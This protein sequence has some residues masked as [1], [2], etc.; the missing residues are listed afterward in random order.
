VNVFAPRK[1]LEILANPPEIPAYRQMVWGQPKPTRANPLQR[2][3]EFNQVTV[4]TLDTPGHSFDHVSFLMKNFMFIGDLVTNPAP[5]IIMKEEDS[6]ELMDSLK[7]VINLDFETA[8]GGHG[9]WDK[10]DIKKT[11]N[12]MLKLKKKVE[13][14]WRMGLN[15]E[16]IVEKIFANVP[17]K[18][19]L[20][21]EMSEHEWSRRN[22]VESILGTRHKPPQSLLSE[23]S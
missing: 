18:V 19:L 15:A 9:V 12:N 20:M 4:T 11:L 16:Q 17:K 8:Y 10:N 5:V 23:K 22:L 6:I 13:T 1:S 3:M 2:K 7:T 14:H 21:E